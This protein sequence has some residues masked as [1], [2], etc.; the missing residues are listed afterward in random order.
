MP[1]GLLSPVA[2]RHKWFKK[3]L[4][5]LLVARRLVKNSAAVIALANPEL[6][7]IRAASIDVPGYVVPN[8]AYVEGALASE[9]ADAIASTGLSDEVGTGR[10]ILFLGRLHRMKG[11]DILLP[12]FEE[13]AKTHSDVS[14]VVAGTADESYSSELNLLRSKITVGDRVRF[15][16]NVSGAQ[17]AHLIGGA[18]VFALT[19][20]SEG[21]PVAVLEAMAAG[22]PV[23]ITPKCNLPE[24]A[25]AGAGIEVMPDAH[26]VARS[27]SRILSDDKL[28]EKMS[29][30]ATQLA[31]RCFD[32]DSVGV[33]VLRI[34]ESVAKT[35][36][37]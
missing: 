21:L 17:K 19:S 28:R 36:S 6:E 5:W 1:R 14:L 31:L 18:S 27:L 10:Y 30:N 16:G 3:K 23:V 35:R 9:K 32:W 25:A 2:L 8:G 4:Y 15:V 34:C 33:R 24:V 11:L 20:Y 12:A 22:V 13:V 29:A 37:A 26:E 7:D